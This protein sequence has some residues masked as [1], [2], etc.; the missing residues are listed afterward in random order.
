MTA[1]NL[2]PSA[3]P[4][5]FT[6]RT[7]RSFESGGHLLGSLFVGLHVRRV[8][9]NPVDHELVEVDHL[10]T[11]GFIAREVNPDERAGFLRARSELQV[12]RRPPPSGFVVCLGHGRYKCFAPSARADGDNGCVRAVQTRARVNRGGA[13]GPLCRGSRPARVGGIGM[14]G[15]VLPRVAAVQ[16]LAGLSA[17]FSP[18]YAPSSHLY[19]TMCEP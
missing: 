19:S 9:G 15:S 13:F 1:L 2:M 17:G 11:Q 5:R 3:P 8:I 10:A 18:A 16:Q 7:R 6:Q 14:S 12:D 4:Q